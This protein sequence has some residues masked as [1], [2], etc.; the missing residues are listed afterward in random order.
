M[1]QSDVIGKITKTA[2]EMYCKKWEGMSCLPCTHGGSSYLSLWMGGLCLG[3]QTL[4]VGFDMRGAW[5]G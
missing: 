3:T 1:G 5:T 2:G 4:A